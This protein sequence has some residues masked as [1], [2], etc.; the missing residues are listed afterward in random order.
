MRALTWSAGWGQADPE[1]D[2]T[3]EPDMMQARNTNLGKKDVSSYGGRNPSIMHVMVRNPLPSLWQICA[4]HPRR[5]PGKRELHNLQ[6]YEAVGT[7]QVRKRNNNMLTAV[8]RGY[9][10]NEVIFILS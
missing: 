3:L 10:Y 4:E 7:A 1:G 8:C 2:H 9:V 6:A 5:R